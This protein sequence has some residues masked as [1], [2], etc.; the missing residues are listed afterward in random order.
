[1]TADPV[2]Q[3]GE[4]SSAESSAAVDEAE[5]V[6]E[7]ESVVTAL[8]SELTSLKNTVAAL[9]VQNEQ[10]VAECAQL[11]TDNEHLRM[12]CTFGV[13]F[14]Q[15]DMSV[16]DFRTKFLTGLPNFA[17][18]L[19]LC[20]LCTGCLPTS[21]MLSPNDILLLILMKLKLNLKHQ[22]LAWRF[23]ISVS[24][25][26]QIINAGLPAVAI[27]LKFTIR[28]PAK[29]EILRTMPLKFRRLY[30]NCRVIVDCTEIFIER[31]SSLTAR[32]MLVDEK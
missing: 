21:L 11:K 31:A 9:Q 17:A 16:S 28:W 10:L 30:P 29:T 2:G 23:Q 27:Q 32:A 25:V 22:D 7:T 19:W 14:L 6:C 8:E 5:T 12:H 26:S 24:K 3:L 15:D 13:S 4:G 20:Q 18:F 1:M